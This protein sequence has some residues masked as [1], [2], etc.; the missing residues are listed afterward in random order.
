[1]A[2]FCDLQISIKWIASCGPKLVQ[3]KKNNLNLN[4][5]LLLIKTVQRQSCAAFF[6]EICSFVI[7]GLIM[8]IWGFAN[9]RL[10]RLRNLRIC[11]IR[12]TQVFPDFQFVDFKVCEQLLRRNGR[13][14]IWCNDHHS[15][16]SMTNMK[17]SSAVN[18]IRFSTLVT[19]TV[20]F[21]TCVSAA[22][23][24]V[25]VTGLRK[26]QQFFI[27]FVFTYNW[28]RLGIIE[29][30]FHLSGKILFTVFIEK[31]ILVLKNYQLT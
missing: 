5:R 12:M 1:M 3:N 10:A 25:S 31:F 16:W 28:T 13:Q 30:N 8:K 19:P 22:K 4:L 20:C 26:R 7:C 17:R 21:H 2:L 14:T 15:F 27:F 23:T 24:I 29:L 18:R 9:C 11:D 6:L